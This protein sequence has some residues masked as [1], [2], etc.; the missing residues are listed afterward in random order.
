MNAEHAQIAADAGVKYL[1]TSDGLFW[2]NYGKF[3][4][5]LDE[6][7]VSIDAIEDRISQHISEAAHMEELAEYYE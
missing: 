2:F 6:S 3:T 5:T 1:G 4:F 7:T